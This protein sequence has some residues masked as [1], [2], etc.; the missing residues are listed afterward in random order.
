M[1]EFDDL[2]AIDDAPILSEIKTGERESKTSPRRTDF[3]LLSA[4]VSVVASAFLPWLVMRVPGQKSTTF[5]LAEMTGG[6]VFTGLA[7]SL[8]A[9]GLI[10]IWRFPT[11]ARLLLIIGAALVGWLAGIGLLALGLLR[12]L[13]PALTVLGIDLSRS[14]IG[15]SYGA[16]LAFAGVNL[17]GIRLVARSSSGERLNSRVSALVLLA[18]LLL[19]ALHQST[20]VVADLGNVTGRIIVSG[21][22]LFGA[23]LV[24]ISVWMTVVLAAVGLVKNNQVFVRISAATLL[25]TS[26][27]KLVQTI[28][29]WSGRGLL[30]LLLPNRVESAVDIDIRWTVH[31]TAVL[32]LIGV[33]LAV[34][35]V[36]VGDR[37]IG[38]LSIESFLPG[39]ILT[40]AMA[41]I[42]SLL[43]FGLLDIGS[44]AP[45]TS[46]PQPLPSTTAIPNT[47]PATTSLT[48]IPPSNNQ[49]S[50]VQSGT[51]LGAVVNVTLG[52]PG[53]ECSGG[54]GV[55][56]GDGTY[57]L[58]N[59]H[60]ISPNAGDP[61]FCESIFIGITT[62]SSQPPTQIFEAEVLAADPVRDLALLRIIAVTPGSL[63]VMIPR[64][65]TLPIDSAVRVIG[66]PGVGGETVTLTRGQIAGYLDD[67][68]GQ[69]YKVDIVL[70]RGNSGGPMVDES[71][72]LV[73][74]ATAVSG[75]DVDCS[76]STSCESVGGN[77]GLVRTILGARD[78]IDR[79]KKGS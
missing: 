18:S 63:P 2:V 5:T 13:L 19:F 48:T 53:D 3:F 57:V 22:S 70:N 66:Y 77:L 52:P 28:F 38:R 14:L 73:G 50:T 16:L 59:E 26:I 72:N 8:T 40:H 30:R 64:Y 27:V 6:R 44:A 36:I 45:S 15:P 47:Y 34:F 43:F 46:T 49:G 65:E 60:V 11:F 76:G 56:I 51:L 25:I 61:S 75:N 41:V 67:E 12:G 58:T 10:L 33:A 20:W 29:I 35:V 4:V 68:G 21:D 78:Y 39:L 69:F 23:L 32:A 7:A 1:S 24:T 55:I 79:A 31:M 9:V 17:I 37:P 42:T 62:S 54:S 74:I 71:G